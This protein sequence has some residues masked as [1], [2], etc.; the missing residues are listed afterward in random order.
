MGRFFKTSGANPLDYMYRMDVP[1]ME[2]VIGA[3]DQYITDNLQ[4]LS[5]L[6]QAATSFPYLQ[7]DEARA[8][9]IA[10]QYS[11][12]IDSITDAIRNDPANWRKQLSSIRDVSKDLQ[13]NYSTGE[14]SKIAGNYGKYK[15]TSDYIDKQVEQFGKDGKGI[16]A[17]RARAYKQF[18]LQKFTEANPN[19]TAYDSKTGEYNAINVFDPMSNMDIR[20]TLSEEL[21]KMKAS[22][23]IRITDQVT[24]NGEYFNK[25]TNK[26][27]G[28]TPDKILQIATDRLNNP[29]LMDYLRQ[30]SMAGIITGVFDSDPRSNNYGK[31]I[32]PYNYNK[33]AISSTEQGIIDKMQ[34]QIQNTSNNSAKAALQEQ[35]DNYTKNLNA[36]S[37]LSWNGNSYL[38]P[39]MRGI[40][41][42]YSY[43]KQDQENDLSANSIWSTKFNQAN[44]NER[45]RLNRSLK[46]TMQQR[47]FDQA[48][49]MQ[50][51]AFE[52]AK[53]LK[54]FEYENKPKIGTAAGKKTVA[55][56]AAKDTINKVVGSTETS[57]FYWQ[58]EA[59]TKMADAVNDEIA[60]TSNTV[61]QLDKALT[62]LKKTS[63]NNTVMIANTENELL[64][65]KNKLNSL[66]SQRDVALDYAIS[67][68]KSKGNDAS[69][70]YSEFHEQNIRDYLSGNAKKQQDE[71]I[72]NLKQVELKKASLSQD[73]PNYNIFMK[74]EYY[75]ALYKKNE[76]VSR[77]VGG[78]RLFNDEVK[79][80][81]NEKLEYGAKNTTNLQEVVGTTKVQDDQVVNLI[82]NDP[83]RYKIMGS[84]GKEVT[85]I[86]FE[87]GTAK[88][89]DLKIISV[90]PSTGIGDKSVEVIAELNGKR[91]I[92]S[93]KGDGNRLNSFFA[94][95]FTNS[96]DP[97]IKNIGSILSSPTAATINDML[98]EMRLNTDKTWYNRD[99]GSMSGDAWV[100]KSVVNPANPK[101]VIK[102]RAR[103]IATGGEPKWEFQFETTN[104][105]L[106]TDSGNTNPEYTTTEDG[107][108][109]KGFVPLAST[110]SKNG[111][112]HNLEDILS[113]F[114]KGL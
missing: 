43:N 83:S 54:L 35:L 2:K 80:S 98:T 101:D 74:Q 68:W 79:S 66:Q 84:D 52:N 99:G 113:I 27:E 108:G 38:A 70:P 24:G 59:P 81:A 32:A 85:G 37:E 77:Y 110:N 15:K 64:T 93:P 105:K 28:I 67:K 9:A 60:T 62:D 14:I 47:G 91:V 92:I 25:Q 114:P 6:D 58:T 16:S 112:Y 107:K 49:A 50:Q 10:D 3:N 33:T 65:A 94:K 56:T 5:G 88:P 63:P 102:I 106:I 44:I 13:S 89:K 75:P 11:G 7:P 17:D 69:H 42:E 73:D 95:E 29:Q 57:P 30:D 104:P 23:D 78:Q 86:S 71:A 40:V 96:T 100:Y 90:A 53:A 51:Q 48:K 19:G 34:K 36:R 22:G 111:I 31:F 72:N 20:K 18:F 76:A 46:E 8:K 39:I 82:T 61:D 4:Q 21:D 55:P 103:S 97:K 1:L 12:Q 87:Q 45:D 41:S 109:I 26:W